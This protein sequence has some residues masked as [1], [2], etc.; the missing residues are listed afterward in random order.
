MLQ[1]G[2]LGTALSPSTA[3]R[4]GRHRAARGS[5]RGR[6]S[7]SAGTSRAP[8]RCRRWRPPARRTPAATAALGR[9]RVGGSALASPRLGMRISASLLRGCQFRCSDAGNNVPRRR[10]IGSTA[11]SECASVSAAMPGR[12]RPFQPFEEGAAGGRDVGELVGDARGIERGHG[13]AAAGHRDELAGLGQRR[14]LARER[15]RALAEG[16]DLE[17]AER[18]VPQQRLAAADDVGVVRDRLGARRRGSSG[19]PASRARRPRAR[20]RPP[21]A[22]PPPPRRAAG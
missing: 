15:E 4:R 2:V 6:P 18:A 10:R 5:T 22:W 19:R 9:Q 20:A 3:P 14:R 16:G 17:G 1:R 13:V 7:A 12:V 11:F 21:R 8:S